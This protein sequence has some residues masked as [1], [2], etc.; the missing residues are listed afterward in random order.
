MIEKGNENLP[1]G[2]EGSQG[3]STQ[4]RLAAIMFTDMV[5]YSALSQKNETLALEL[6]EEHR[7]ILRAIFPEYFGKEI[8][9]AGDS[10]F[11][12]F[13]S[14]VDAANCAIKIQTTLLNRNVTAEPEKQIMIRIGLHI[15]DVV[16]L[17]N[18]VHGDGVNIAARL[19]PLCTPEGICL[20]EDFARTVQNKLEYPVIKK[21]EVTLKNI[22][23]PMTIYC[24]ELPWVKE[25]V[26]ER[27]VSLKVSRKNILKYAVP[28]AIL[29]L[30]VLVVLSVK[31]FYSSSTEDKEMHTRIAVLPF[32]NIGNDFNDEYFADGMTEQ[33]ISALSNLSG[34]NVIARTSVMKY[35]NAGKDLKEIGQELKVGTVLEGSIRMSRNKA[36]I[37]VNLID[38]STQENIW[39]MDYDKEL[40]DIFM[41][42][43]EIAQNVAQNLEVKLKRE[44]EERLGKK[45]LVNS[46]AYNAYIIGRSYLN[47]RSV[48]GVGKS[49]SYFENAIKSDSTFALAYSGLADAYTLIGAAGY[50][51][52]PIEEAVAKAKQ[53]V[54]KAIEIDEN[55]AEARASLAYIKFRLEWEFDE[56]EIEFKRA[57]ELGPSYA[58]A[59][60]WYALYLALR[61]RLKEALDL[62]KRAQELNPLSA[63]VNNGIGRI[64]FF[65]GDFKKAVLQFNKTIQMDQNY[66]EAHFSL[67]MT[68]GAMNEYDKA[69]KE[70]E[71]AVELSSRRLVIIA[72]LAY[73]YQKRGMKD[74]ALDIINELK[75]RSKTEDVSS[76]NYIPYYIAL[77]DFDKVFELF[78]EAYQKKYG[79]LLYIKTDHLFGTDGEFR[80]DPRFNDLLKRIGI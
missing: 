59:H 61:G 38:I 47:R 41:V 70:L 43:S 67:G 53:N 74:K 73:I 56:A 78:E 44:E 30:I 25:K 12:E 33:I 28:P 34:L 35:K 22:S 37:T 19:E 49:I 66:A 29:I 77:K 14:A 54:M 55:L 11:V 51:L 45:T 42:Q 9:T 62:M 10:F 31:Y 58:Q 75:E 23:S 76:F 13:Q 24:V 63:S 1:A 71:K 15:G 79:L 3:K 20:S 65:M 16:Q 6:L 80:N 46:E 39:A 57:I 68:Y 50:S 60:E 18:N 27:E 36:R 52:I 26:L 32:L 7:K 5:G 4:R 40:Q 2:Q 48:D 17:G 72:D 21:G 64:Y 8:D 69:I